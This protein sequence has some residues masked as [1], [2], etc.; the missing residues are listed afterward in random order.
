[1]LSFLT[2]GLAEVPALP[3]AKNAGVAGLV[4]KAL[5]LGSKPLYP[6]GKLYDPYPQEPLGERIPI[7]LLPGRAEESHRNAWWE[8]VNAAWLQ[9]KHTTSQPSVYT[10]YKPYVYLFNSRESL[11]SMTQT[12]NGAFNAFL[13]DIPSQRPIAVV[14]YSLGGL[15]LEEAW[16]Q[17]PQFRERITE[18]YAIAVPFGGSP[19]FHQTWYADHLKKPIKGSVRSPLRKSM[20][21]LG[22]KG[23]LKGRNHLIRMMHVSPKLAPYGIPEAY[24]STPVVLT[25]PINPKRDAATP[26]RSYYQWLEH[27]EATTHPETSPVK[28]LK[29]KLTVYAGYLPNAVVPAQTSLGKARYETKPSWTRRVLLFPFRIPGTFINSSALPLYGANIHQTF[30]FGNLSLRQVSTSQPTSLKEHPYRYNDGFLSLSS[31]LYLPPSSSE[32]PLAYTIEDIVSRADVKHIR[33][34]EGVDH[35]DLGHY[36]LNQRYLPTQDILAPQHPAQ[37]PMMWLFED[38]MQSRASSHLQP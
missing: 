36:R 37:T 21:T 29:E 11:P 6:T 9:T 4:T 28:G 14:S 12:F 22:L 25:K 18:A 2:V 1:M 15:L 34:F 35:V 8:K 19:M 13:T 20:D 38:L 32:A 33:I 16:I 26:S 5:A 17:N 24:R 7:I 31:A 30:A 10:Y 23:Y 27:S 3:K